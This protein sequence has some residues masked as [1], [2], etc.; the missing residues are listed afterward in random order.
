MEENK[1]S[2]FFPN[3]IPRKYVVSFVACIISVAFVFGYYIYPP[4]NFPT[5]TL[6]KIEKGESL[7]EVASQ[8]QTAGIIQ[9]SFW[10][11]NFAI[12]FSGERS[13]LA[14][15]YSFKKPISVISVAWRIV[16]GDYEVEPIKITI[17]EG[18]SVLQIADILSSKLPNFNKAEF[19]KIAKPKEGYL[20]PETY[21]F[22]PD[23]E[24]QFIIDT[25]SKTFGDKILVISD[26]IKLFGKS[27][28]DV[29][30]MAS[31][32]EEEGKNLENRKIIAGILWKRIS[33]KMALQVDATFSYV[34][35]KT[36]NLTTADLAIDSPYN[37]YKYRGLPPGP[38]T[39]PGIDS[40]NATIEP[41]KTPYFYYISDK[42]GNMHYAKTYAE[43][44][45]NV[46][47]YLN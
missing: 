28:K 5:G 32:V 36:K 4:Q 12:I 31:I 44:L 38:I 16:N 47:K 42:E 23:A 24:P 43:H 3:E 11:K 29:I 17:P 25:M 40:I 9:S 13:I 41:T 39:N 6:I 21:L 46:A 35:G 14:G 2:K 34:N 33:L 19:I 7:G 45:A 10:L 1:P 18:T 27:I 22:L 26:K 8:F 20:F 15:V 37:T 30:T